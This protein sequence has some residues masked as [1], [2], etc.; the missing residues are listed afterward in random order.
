MPA[1]TSVAQSPHYPL[2][3]QLFGGAARAAEPSKRYQPHRLLDRVRDATRVGHLS[4]RTEQAYIGW[5]RRFILFHGKKHPAQMGS[6]A[7]REFLAHFAVRDGVSASTQNQALCALVFLYKRVLGQEL[8]LAVA[9]DGAR[10]QRVLVNDFTGHCSR[11][12]G[13]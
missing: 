7:V 13:R 6:D 3:Q 8:G 4:H 12:A 1:T 10:G 2:T 5:I 9:A 11:T